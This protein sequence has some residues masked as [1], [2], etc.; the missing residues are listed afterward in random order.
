MEKW[1]ERCCTIAFSKDFLVSMS[2]GLM[3][4]SMHILIASAAFA[5][6]RIFAGDSAGVLEDPGR[7]RP[8]ASTAVAIVFAVYY[9]RISM[10]S[11]LTSKS[12]TMPP[13]APLPGHA[14]C[15]M[16]LMISSF[17]RLGSASDFSV[18]Y[19]KAPCAS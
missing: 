9:R 10:T 11:R 4:R 7:D 12:L 17:V 2:R 18:S 5:H 16:S 1:K 14:C 8:I 15:S 19:R 13:H 3:F 6:S